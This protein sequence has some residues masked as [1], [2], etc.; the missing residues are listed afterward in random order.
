M[1]GYFIVLQQFIYCFY[2]EA[3]KVWCCVI[4]GFITSKSALILLMFMIFSF[5]MLLLMLLYCTFLIIWYGKLLFE[6]ILRITSW[7][8]I[9]LNRIWRRTNVMSW[10]LTLYMLIIFYVS[11]IARRFICN[12][13]LNNLSICILLSL[14]LMLLVLIIGYIFWYSCYF[15]LK[16]FL[17]FCLLSLL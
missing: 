11:C 9:K 8:I 13:L 16:L 7:M 17:L 15:F 3:W 14:I 10:W 5:G 1:K 4:L 2:S 6:V 12:L